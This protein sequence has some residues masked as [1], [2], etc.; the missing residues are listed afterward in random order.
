MWIRPIVDVKFQQREEDDEISKRFTNVK[1]K[2]IH[3]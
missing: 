2:L 1:C 3:D